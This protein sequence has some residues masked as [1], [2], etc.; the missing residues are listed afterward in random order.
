MEEIK[1]VSGET[2]TA[3]TLP[4]KKSESSAAMAAMRGLF[5]ASFVELGAYRG[6]RDGSGRHILSNTLTG[7]GAVADTLVYAFAQDGEDND[8]A[9]TA[10]SAEKI[11]ALI[12]RSCDENAP[13][14]GFFNSCGARLEDGVSALAGYGKIMRAVA[15]KGGHGPRIAVICG[16]CTGGLA[17]IAEMFD[18]VI[19]TEDSDFY[20]NPPYIARDALEED[21]I[22]APELGTAHAAA[23]RGEVAMLCPSLDKA[24][25]EVIRLLG[26]ISY[27]A[28]ETNDDYNR[29]TARV[30]D[31]MKDPAYDAHGV[32][33]EICDDGEYFESK[34][35]YASEL[36]TVIGRICGDTV[37]IVA[38]NPGHHD[39]Y[40]SERAAGKAYAFVALAA[41]LDIPVVT[42]VDTAGFDTTSYT[43][44]ERASTRMAR[45]ATTY[46]ESNNT[47]VTVITGRAYGTASVLL[48]SRAIGSDICLALEGA[49]I[50]IITPETAVQFMYGDEIDSAADPREAR[51][52]RIAEWK[53]MHGGTGEAA[54]EG[55]IDD[56]IAPAELRARIAAAVKEFR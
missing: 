8:G 52:A 46:A 12:N 28:G 17:V 36:L 10:V 21:G 7:Y 24:I 3:D 31:I 32:I 33:A 13:L 20:V 40:L 2:R 47:H 56:I 55:E 37:A 22:P 34:P 38:S 27:P 23:L 48:G 4:Q 54:M 51:N 14:V 44:I 50:S 39:G 11:V 45:L 41:S 6:Y 16:S 9:I 29:S 42:L 30:A 18:V 1:T 43:E 15:A 25:A 53:E 5:G 26:F 49:D 35:G 19:A